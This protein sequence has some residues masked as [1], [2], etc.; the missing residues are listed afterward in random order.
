MVNE[1]ARGE[2]LSTQRRKVCPEAT[3]ADTPSVVVPE[4]SEIAIRQAVG[5]YGHPG[6][7]K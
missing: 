1:D 2:K 3:L 5:G 4:A 7:V 6:A